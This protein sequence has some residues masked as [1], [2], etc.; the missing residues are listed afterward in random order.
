MSHRSPRTIARATAVAVLALVLPLVLAPP[1]SAAVT[2]SRAELRGSELRLEGRALANRTITVDGAAMG[3]SDGAGGFRITRTGYRAPA[4][5]TVDV[6]DGSTTPAVARL[7]GCTVTST[8]P[9]TTT[10]TI[11]P[12]VAGFVANVGTPFLE[13]FV[14][15]PTVTSPSS[16]RIEAGALPAGLALTP[17]PITSPRP[18]P[19]NAIRIQGTP[20]TEQ[21]TTVTLRGTDAD[22]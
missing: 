12:D 9:P 5:C 21:S 20:T 6:D 2:V 16:F 17:I 19:Q 4:D 13:T 3:T 15:G 10:V 14:L 7:S 11:S 8:P 22:G 18:F 1:A